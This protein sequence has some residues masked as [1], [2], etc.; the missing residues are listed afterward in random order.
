MRS[1]VLAGARGGAAP[2][3]E[4]QPA[5]HCEIGQE[6]EARRADLRKQ[7]MQAQT[8]D[9]D[10]DDAEVDREPDEPDR[11]EDGELVAGAREAPELEDMADRRPVDEYCATQEGNCGGRKVRN[12]DNRDLQPEQRDVERESCARRANVGN[13]FASEAHG[14]S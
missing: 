14:S 12:T 7:V 4:Q 1:V 9:A 13:Q 5:A 8:R 6:R 3:G 10:V 11:Q 2:W